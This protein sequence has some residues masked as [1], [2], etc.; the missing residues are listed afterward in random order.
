MRLNL[1]CGSEP[2]L[3]DGTVN[4]D[5]VDLP[6]VDV[7]H[8][9]D[10]APWP[11]DDGSVQMIIAQDVFEHVAEPVRF[12]TESHRVLEAGGTL[13]I[14]SPHFRHEDAFTDPTHRR[15]CTE[16]TWDYWINGTELFKRHNAAYG[17]VSFGL[18]ARQVMSGAIFI[19]LHKI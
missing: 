15:F 9:L 4:V 14:K 10:V 19:H 12:M 2:R 8:D 13:L 17:G 3:D 1:G 7:V 6:T 11:W 16:H 5:I 18:L